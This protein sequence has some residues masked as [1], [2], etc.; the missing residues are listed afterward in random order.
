MIMKKNF[1]QKMF[2]SMALAA[3]VLTANAA[4]RLLIV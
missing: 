4:D 1:L 2:C 3:A